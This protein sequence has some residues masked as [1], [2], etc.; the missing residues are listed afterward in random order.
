M[1]LLALDTST[2]NCSAA[3]KTAAGLSFRRELAPRRHAELI[4]DMVEE[5][6]SERGLGLDELD[7]IA[8]GSG[9]G[10]F[11]GVR[12][13]ASAAQGLALGLGLRLAPVSSL[14][15]LAL[16]ALEKGPE[17]YAAAAIDARMGEV[18]LAVYERAG[19]SLRELSGPE[20]L[21]PAAALRRIREVLGTAP[22][23]GGGSG[24]D[25]LNAEETQKNLV[26]RSQ[27]PDSAYI[28]KL[29]EKA[30]SRGLTLD[31][32]AALPL[33]VRNEVTWKKLTEQ[34][35]G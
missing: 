34:S 1:N 22:A 18:Y 2:E 11:T 9:P 29:G 12:V 17:A 5:M 13:A 30:F 23:A 20:V 32:A 4:L 7:G 26:K 33:Y 15:A 25:C 8:F 28:I 19:D 14:E 10:S 35:T 31:P 24:I 16:E 6:L 21:R 27:F 3:L